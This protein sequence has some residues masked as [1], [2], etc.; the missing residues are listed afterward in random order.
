ML[1]SRAGAISPA[2]ASHL[3]ASSV[4]RAAALAARA[5]LL[6]FAFFLPI[7]IAGMQ[8]GLG[9]AA[10]GVAVA[11]A[12]GAPVWRRTAPI[13]WPVLLLVAAA[14]LS[15]ALAWAAGTR[16]A[17]PFRAT[18]WKTFLTPLVVVA[19]LRLER[20]GDRPDSPRAR[21]LAALAA[22]SAGAIV[23]GAIALVQP[24]TGFDPL[25]WLHTAPIRTTAERAAWPGHFH[26]LG[27]FTQYALLPLS[28]LPPLALALPVCALA[29]LEPWRRALLGAAAAAA[30]VASVL[31][32]ARSAW[33]ALAVIAGVLVVASAR[34][35][36]RRVGAWAAA[37][38][39]ALGAFGLAVPGIRT[40]VELGSTLAANADRLLIWRVCG[41]VR[42]DHPWV[43][44]GLGNFGRV[45][46]PY[47]DRLAPGWLA[48]SA[49]HDAFLSFLV[50][51]GP[52]LLAAGVGWFGLLAA[53]F[54]R[55]RRAAVDAGDRLAA[56]AAAGALAALAATL[57]NA[58]VH[59]VFHSSE[60]AYA[61]GLALGCAA[62]LARPAQ[63]LR[64]RAATGARPP[65]AAARGASRT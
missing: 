19:A 5:G 16:P 24:W 37:A 31:S 34:A 57:S 4:S 11:G 18:L 49:C 42:A 27:F 14:I 22:W 28:L 46:G 62:V 20:A 55:A 39:T 36:P 10:A 65:R 38:G 13:A 30:A 3:P 1:P 6:A 15:V 9:V 56:A 53:G 26:A 44:T 54:L 35:A 59:D 12:L 50:E 17:G 29:P 63:G 58:L 43:G 61:I 33:V 48:R 47:F 21:A 8:I 40:R 2:A 60:S 23:V 7:S 64:G 41:E 45:A 32:L 51:G 25:S 52:L